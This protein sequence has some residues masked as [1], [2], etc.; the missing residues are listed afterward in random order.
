M[1]GQS[2]KPSWAL[3]ELN[4]RN[5]TKACNMRRDKGPK[6]KRSILIA[7][8]VARCALAGADYKVTRIPVP[9]LS[10]RLPSHARPFPEPLG[11]GHPQPGFKFR[12]TKGFDWTPE[13]YME[14]VPV[15]AGLKMNFLMNCYTSLFSSSKYG[16]WTN[17]WWKPIPDSKK[18]AYAKVIRAC[19]ENGITFCFA[20]H[21]Q[22]CSPRRLDPGSES[23][24]EQ[25][26]QH[27]AW[28]QSQGVKWF[29]V[30][31]DDVGW[32]ARGAEFG[33]RQHAEFVNK[34]FLRLREKD[35]DTQLIFCP[36]PYSGDGTGT[37]N[38]AYLGALARVM[39]PDVYV[40]WT[41]DGTVTGHITRR[42]AESYKGIVKHRLFLWDNYPV[43]DGNPTLHLGP[44]SGRAA[45]LGD[46][47]DGYISNPMATQNQMN[48]IP[49]ATCADYAYNPWAYDP[50][51]SIGQVIRRT[52]K[53]SAQRHLLA[54][55][56]EAYPGFIVTG[57][58]TG[59]NP[60]RAKFE[61]LIKEQ[62]RG[63]ALAFVQHMED[64]STRLDKEFPDHF[65]ASRKTVADDVTWMKGQLNRLQ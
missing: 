42:A 40:F 27:F 5:L 64:V 13:Q 33:G 62:S 32:G 65:R 36:V 57:G 45:D 25:F 56:V 60:V 37:D 10:I 24:F 7:A 22:Y 19:R 41:G 55:L 31:M 14:E 3:A 49:L 52:G 48:R 17:E 44:L 61:N 30:S 18:E 53:N 4:W 29:S 15:L 38:E 46:V 8:M 54:E 50:A 28:A 51:R 58:G 47:I 1:K 6:L 34:V 59:N 11:P 21:P 26:F 43:N 9:S 20:M 16:S 35:P 23:D 63:E 12:G 39:D 2:Q